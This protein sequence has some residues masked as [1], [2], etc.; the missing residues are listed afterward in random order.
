MVAGG[1]ALCAAPSSN[2]PAII[3]EPDASTLVHPS[4]TAT[5]DQHANLVL[6]P[7]PR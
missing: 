2:G 3:G 1:Q 7:S 5:V 4:W 6:S